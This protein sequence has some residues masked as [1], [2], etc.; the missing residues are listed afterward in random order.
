M[1]AHKEEQ[2]YYKTDHHWTSLGA[3]Y[4]F[5]TLAASLGIANPA[6]EYT[7]YPV[8]HTFSGTLASK[9]GYNKSEDTIEIYVPKTTNI[10]Y[11]VEYVD[12]AVKSSSMYVSDALEQKDQYEVFF[13]GNHTRVDISTPITE[14]KNL[15]ILKD[16]YANCFIQFLTPYF[17]TITMIDARYYY[18]DIDKLIKDNGITDILILYNVNTFMTDNSLADVLNIED[19]EG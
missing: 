5:D 12:E 17:R 14:N 11:M 9:S 13:G 8:S 16:S 3:K 10:S 19:D 7:V 1:T 2:I 6:K 18:D 4:A 15:L